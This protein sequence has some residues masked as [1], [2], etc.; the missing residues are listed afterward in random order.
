MRNRLA[1]P[2]LAALLAA[3]TVGPHYEKPAPEAAPRFDQATTEATARPV[4]P[5]LW[6]GFGSDELDALIER[7]LAANTTIAQAAANLNEARALSGLSTYSW[8]PT[9]GTSAAR[10]KALDR[11]T[12]AAE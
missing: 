4:E 3:C 2:L 1:A 10:E 8:F 9:V 11:P 12:E 6:A 7:A 5:R